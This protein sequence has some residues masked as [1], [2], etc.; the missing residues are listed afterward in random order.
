M[1]MAGGMTDGGIVVGNTYDKYA[2]PSPIV[3][4]LVGKFG[5]HLDQLVAAVAPK[6]IH[7][8]G[9]GAGY[10]VLRWRAK[11]LAA[12]GSDFSARV[13]ALARENARVCGVP[14]ELFQVRDIY[15][16][17]EAEDAADLVVCCEVLEHLSDPRAALRALQRVARNRLIVSVPREPLW[18]A[19][20]LL[21]GRYISAWGNTPGHVQHWSTGAFIR[22]ISEYFAVTDCLMPLPWTM[23][24][25]RSLTS[26]H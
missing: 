16:V 19:L 26:I 17:T 18:R 21:R 2:S 7:E 13:V 20:N 1:K 22:V 12:R 14:E 9:C 5:R 3:R 11:G 25:C 15:D 24:L 10:W 23:L 8:V 4:H 6:S